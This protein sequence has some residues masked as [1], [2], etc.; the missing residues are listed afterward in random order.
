MAEFKVVLSDP[1]TG[2]SYQKELKDNS[3]EFLIGKKIGEKIAGESMDLTGYEFEIT[4]GSDKSGFPMRRDISGAV[5]AK[6]LAVSG[7]GLKKTEKGIR[8]RKT[9]FGNTVDTSIVQVNMKILKHGREKLG[10]EEPSTEAKEEK[11]EAKPKE[12]KKKAKAEDQ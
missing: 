3:A 2:K 10:G 6:I 12:E 5:R 8:R 9:V 4:G 7:V 1:K 11:A